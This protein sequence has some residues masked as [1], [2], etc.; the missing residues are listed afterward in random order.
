MQGV[1]TARGRYVD[2]PRKA[3][4]ILWAREATAGEEGPGLSSFAMLGT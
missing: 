1:L 2:F 4:D 3:T